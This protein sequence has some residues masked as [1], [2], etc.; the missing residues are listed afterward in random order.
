MTLRG[1]LALTLAITVV[2]ITF[3]LML[4]LNR[5][6]TSV[7][8]EEM[9]EAGADRLETIRDRCE[10]RERRPR[11]GRRGRRRGVRIY[12]DQLR[13]RPGVRELEPELRAAL[14]AGDDIATIVVRNPPRRLVA[15]RMDWTG[16]CSV[17]VIS[18]PEPVLRGTVLL[19]ALIP[20]LA[21]V[22]IALLT[23]GPLVRRVRR[24][25]RGVREGHN[26][27]EEG[28]D[29]LAELSRA[30]DATRAQLVEKV[31]ALAKR[32]AALTRYVSN[33]TH[34]VMIPL[35]V[36]Q[37]HLKALE[38]HASDADATVLAQAIEESHYLASLMQNLSTAARLEGAVPETQ[39]A[40]VDMG[41]LIER[42]IARHAPVAKSKG[43]ALDFAVPEDAVAIA[44]DPTLLEQAI[45]NLVHNAIR[46]GFA[47]GHVA[48]V[49]HEG[50]EFRLD[51][52]DDGPGVDDATLSRMTEP[53]FRSEEARTR[54][55]DGQGLGLAIARDVAERHGM[56]L[57]FTRG[58]EGQ[59][60]RATLR[61]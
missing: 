38:S 42:V 17:I 25:T 60:L 46:Y 11:R 16:P 56:T 6:R 21:A 13:P 19:G 39:V 45:S 34:D 50:P 18:R 12:D 27:A 23:A 59:G 36:L 28:S 33:T 5:W 31:D 3:A 41:S 7:T 51:V 14:D 35:T 53:R 44:G 30:F 48:V 52:T 40:E 8:V 55:P 20:S 58:P 26:V 37:G 49:L 54:H 61:G 57:E 22:F 15:R 43:I 4:G 29:E 24:L 2:P 32:D 47:S 1:R 9:A 10:E